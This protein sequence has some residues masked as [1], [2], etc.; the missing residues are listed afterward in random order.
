MDQLKPCRLRKKSINYLDHLQKSIVDNVTNVYGILFMA[1]FSLLAGGLGLYHLWRLNTNSEKSVDKLEAS[2]LHPTVLFI[3]LFCSCIA[4]VPYITSH[5][6]RCK[7]RFD[8]TS[9]F[10]HLDRSFVRKELL[11]LL[12][13]WTALLGSWKKRNAIL[14]LNNN[15]IN[16][17]LPLN[18]ISALTKLTETAETSKT[19]SFTNI[20]TAGIPMNNIST[21]SKLSEPAAPINY[22][23]AGVKTLFEITVKPIAETKERPSSNKSCSVHENDICSTFPNVAGPIGVSNISA[24][25]KTA[26]LHSHIFDDY[27][28][29]LPEIA[30]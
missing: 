19:S 26:Q 5:A 18:N 13:T 16:N 11:L 14:P 12:K 1:I 25:S 9:Q 8:L 10:F 15:N 2:M 3:V 29:V 27:G 28:T 7:L 17:I 24:T 23:T 21:V 30:Y 4:L 6:L 20:A 22:K